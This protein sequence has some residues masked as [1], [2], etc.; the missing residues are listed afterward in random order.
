MDG[1]AWQRAVT[2]QLYL[3]KLNYCWKRYADDVLAL[4][5]NDDRNDLLDH[6]N[7][8]ISDMNFTYEQDKIAALLSIHIS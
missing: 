2:S 3:S 6:V 5:P 4:V 8:S 1:F 7:L